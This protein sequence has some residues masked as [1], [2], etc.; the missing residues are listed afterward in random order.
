MWLTNTQSNTHTKLHV[1]CTYRMDGKYPFVLSSFVVKYSLYTSTIPLPNMTCAS[2]AVASFLLHSAVRPAKDFIKH[3][4]QTVGQ[5]YKTRRCNSLK[6]TRSRDQG[7]CLCQAGPFTARLPQCYHHHHYEALGKYGPIS[8]QLG[9]I[10]QLPK[11][12]IVN[13]VC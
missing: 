4:G 9:F 11:I 12:T 5:V 8:I 2:R 13:C 1:E 10:F 3:A 7:A 6:N